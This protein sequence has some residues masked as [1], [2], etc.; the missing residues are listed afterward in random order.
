[1]SRA[2]SI[3]RLARRLPTLGRT[4]RHLRPDQ[5]RAQLKH[6]LVGLPAPARIAEPTPAPAATAARCDFLPPPAHVRSLGD[7]R[8]ELLARSFDLECETDWGSTRHGPLFAYHLHQHDYL[9]L[10]GF[11]P[12]SRVRRMID[13]I[14]RH[15]AGV[16]WDPHPISLRLL[17]WGKLMLSPGALELEGEERA[18][19]LASMADQAETLAR[20]IEVRLQANHLLSN[21]VA[22]VWAGLLLD[23]PRSDAWLDQVT[24]LMREIGAQ[25]HLDGGHEERSPMYHALLLE[26][27]LDLLN[28]ACATPNR[29]PAG[30]VETLR[31]AAAR[32]LSALELWTH[33]DGRI[34]LFGDSGFDI[35][36]EPLVLRRYAERLG[37]ASTVD[38]APGSSASGELPQT[39]Y[40][41]LRRGRATLIASLSGPAPL[42]Q[43]GHAHC[44]ALAFELSFDATRCVTDTG[45]YEY[46]VGPR[47]QRARATAS[48]AT[49]AIDGEEQAEI[50]SAHRVGG[51]PVVDRIGANGVD[52]VEARCQPWS[53]PRTAH[54]RAFLL[55]PE[56]LTILDRIEGRCRSVRFVLPFDPIWFLELRPD[57]RRALASRSEAS[58]PRTAGPSRVEL[59]LF[60]GLVWRIE[61]GP[62]YPSFG[63]EVERAILIGEGPPF[64][65]ARTRIVPLD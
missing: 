38:G 18:E 62:Y 47:R 14:R 46:Q 60:E 3:V 26:S 8:I 30:L 49:I 7:S 37:V 1:M 28:L 21:R 12:R 59:T 11:T 54:R 55:D 56:G 51:R 19:L 22:L 58:G 10:D 24:P 50:W 31:A 23:H 2:A 35:A 61:Q 25:I 52:R 64:A 34:G 32:M 39:G 5:A 53:R 16:G 43:P 40:V 63:R 44:D 6:L 33:P 57:G 65:E 48:H 27:L 15:R 17:V 9:R 20:R 13:W 45:S 36:A 4:L 42:H 41:R 29:A